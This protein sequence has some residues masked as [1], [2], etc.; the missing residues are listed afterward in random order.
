MNEVELMHTSLP[1]DFNIYE[2]VMPLFMTALGCLVDP[3]FKSA[4]IPMSKTQQNRLLKRKHKQML[5]NGPVHFDKFLVDLCLLLGPNLLEMSANEVSFVYR[6]VYQ[7][8]THRFPEDMNFVQL[9]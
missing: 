4:Q 3:D 7:A 1:V 9:V 6:K 5:L 8:M 2:R